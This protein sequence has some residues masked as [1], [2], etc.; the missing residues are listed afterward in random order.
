MVG[1]SLAGGPSQCNQA[2]FSIVHTVRD[3]AVIPEVEL[4]SV[5][6]KVLLAAVLVNTLHA[7]LEDAVEAFNR[8]RVDA[9][10]P[11]KP[12]PSPETPKP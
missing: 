11:S 8:V 12:T 2:P 5:A 3:P 6:V 9:A 4:R 7:P 10:A 1:K